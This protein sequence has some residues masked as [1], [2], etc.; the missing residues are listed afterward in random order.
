[1]GSTALDFLR[2]TVLLVVTPHCYDNYFVEFN[3]FDGPCFSSTLSKGLGLG[4]ILGSLLVKLPQI[5][6]IYKNKS[7]EGISLLSVSLDLTA[8][9][10]YGSYSFLKQFP[11]SA[12]GDA[13][14]LA[15]Q[16]VLVAVLVLHYGG[17]TINAIVYLVTYLF[18]TFV[19]ISGLTPIDVLW[20][21]Q[22]FN[23]FIV[24]SGK[25]TQAY[26]N[27]RNGHTG[28]LSAVTLVMLFLGSLARIFTSIQETGDRM[29]ILTYI[30]SSLANGVLVAQ[31][32]YYWNITP[33]KEKVQ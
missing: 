16:T 27:F 28:Q 1:M 32:L 7:G 21:L 14:F 23:I 26:G 18:I 17:S 3:F 12:W 20:S 10:I 25:L 24:V 31:L 2:R 19:L 4:I 29:V 11:F 13:T 22:G 6:K 8:I 30:V 33:Q 15:V 9:S 5:L